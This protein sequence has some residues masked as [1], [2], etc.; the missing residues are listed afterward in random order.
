MT[1]R[2]TLS[3]LSFFKFKAAHIRVAE[4][5]GQPWFVGS[6]ICAA[7]G[8]MNSGNGYRRLSAG[9][10]PNL[11]RVDVGMSPRRDAMIISESGL[12]KLVMR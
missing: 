5:D 11:R 4:V 1:F 10:R 2:R 12:Y 8:I 7:L 6:N 3:N 9:E